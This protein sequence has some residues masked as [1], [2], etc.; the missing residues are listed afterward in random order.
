MSNRGES[1]FRV[2]RLVAVMGA[3]A[4]FISACSRADPSDTTADPP[5]STTTAPADTPSSSTT[6][7]ADTPPANCNYV[8]TVA[9]SDVQYARIDGVRPTLLSL[10]VYEPDRIGDCVDSPIMVYV[11]GGA[12]SIGNKTGAVADKI[13]WF[14]E[15]GWVFVSVNYRLSPVSLGLGLVDLDPD[16]IKYPTHNE[17]VASAVAW[18]HDHA[19]DYSADPDVMSIMGHSAGAGIAA[20]LASDERYLGDHGMGLDDIRCA[21]PLDTAAF[22]VRERIEKSLT[23]GLYL[24]AFGDDPAIWDE[25]SPINHVAPGKP[26]PD[27][28]VVARGSASRIA[29]GENFAEALREAGVPVVV[30]RADELSHEGVNDAVG[31]ADDDLITPALEEFL[32][33]CTTL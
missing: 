33:G 10:D 23:A 4:I 22:D 13:S 26:I 32:G 5:S 17:D 12:W 30:V 2:R 6:A 29:Q 18:V 8:G 1:G 31:R 9:D 11:H 25:A 21:V 20:A 19:G 28:L 3:A 14:N 24:N 16:R 15:R 7:P 27:F